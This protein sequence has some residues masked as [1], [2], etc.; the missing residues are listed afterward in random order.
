MFVIKPLTVHQDYGG[1][2]WNEQNLMRTADKQGPVTLPPTPTSL[3]GVTD[4]LKENCVA[5]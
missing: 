2:I 1:L 3:P 5:T 4:V